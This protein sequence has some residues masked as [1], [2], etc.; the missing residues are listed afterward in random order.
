VLT[1]TV[2]REGHRD[3]VFVSGKGGVRGHILAA[4]FLRRQYPPP[5]KRERPRQAPTALTRINTTGPVPLYL[6]G[7][8]GSQKNAMNRSTWTHVAF[9]E[10]YTYLFV[11]YLVFVAAAAVDEELLRDPNPPYSWLR[12]LPRLLSTPWRFLGQN[13]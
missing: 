2:N 8:S 12:Q 7:L 4:W 5:H 13:T 6:L 11:G 9:Y 10:L 3:G 1:V